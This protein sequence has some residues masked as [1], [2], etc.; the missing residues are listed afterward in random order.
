[1]KNGILG[2]W[3]F[4]QGPTSEKRT[5]QELAAKLPYAIVAQ[6]VRDMS[7]SDARSRG[8]ENPSKRSK[9]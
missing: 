4:R 3:D 8:L 5:Y 2:L 6:F 7:Q 9:G 1:M